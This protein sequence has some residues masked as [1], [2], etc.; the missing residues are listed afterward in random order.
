MNNAQFRNR[1]H[2]LI[3]EMSPHSV[4]IIAAAPEVLRNGDCHYRYRQN[5]DFYYLTGFKE[6][7]SI[8]IFFSADSQDKFILFNRPR[9]QAEETWTGLRAGQEGACKEY[10][11]DESYSITEI[12]EIILDILAKADKIY[13]TLGKNHSFDAQLIAWIKQ[14]RKKERSGIN[15]PTGI[16][17]LENT[18][19]TGQSYFYL[20]RRPHE[21][22]K[23]EKHNLVCAGGPEKV[24]PNEDGQEGK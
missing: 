15:I 8:A 23:G 13:S 18:D 12:N 14:L 6:P 24:L 21:H 16:E 17:D 1:R 9:N 10:G 4:A 2:R 19:P 3:Q 11:A 7:E 5:S 20:T 22:S